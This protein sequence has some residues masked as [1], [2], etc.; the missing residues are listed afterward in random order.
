MGRLLVRPSNRT[1]RVGAGSA[2]MA[3]GIGVALVWML[4]YPFP[5]TPVLIWC[6]TTLLWGWILVR[7]TDPPWGDFLGFWMDGA[8]LVS[9]FTFSGGLS[10][11]FLFLLYLKVLALYGIHLEIWNLQAAALFTL[12]GWIVVGLTGCLTPPPLYLLSPPGRPGRH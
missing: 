8:L 7:F 10:S 9:L 6:L 2:W 3:S 4:G 12:Y 11:P 1:A 5:R